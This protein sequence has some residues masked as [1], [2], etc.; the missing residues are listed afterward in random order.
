MTPEQ[1]DLAHIWDMLQAAREVAFFVAGRTKAEF[2]TNLMLRRSVERSIEIV[3]EASR[4]VSKG[5]KSQHKSVPWTKIYGQ[6]NR[7]AHEYDIVDP[8]TIWR[9]A[10]VHIPV[11][12]AELERILPNPPAHSPTNA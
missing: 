11:L 2:D 12:I 4:R 8:E 3:G 10:T 9:V 6:R 5:F 7:L 1:R